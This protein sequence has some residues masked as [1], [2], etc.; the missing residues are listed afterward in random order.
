MKAAVKKQELVVV[1]FAVLA[2]TAL[3]V[4]A[5]VQELAS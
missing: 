1:S 5:V 2:I 4:I 3:I